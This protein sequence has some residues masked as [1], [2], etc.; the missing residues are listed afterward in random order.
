MTRG[1]PPLVVWVGPEVKTNCPQ[2][3]VG[4]KDGVREGVRDRVA[5]RVDVRV[6][7]TTN[8]SAFAEADYIGRK[9]SSRETI[10][11]PVTHCCIF[12]KYR[13]TLVFI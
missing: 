11:A 7:V 13:L 10:S 9:L 3:G 12:G 1:R 5:V 6:G 8:R 4:V 2:F